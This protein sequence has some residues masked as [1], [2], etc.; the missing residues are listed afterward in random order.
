MERSAGVLLAISSLPSRYGIGDFGSYAKEFIQKLHNTGFKIWQI[1]PLNPLGFGN[2]P[3]QPYSSKAMDEIYISLELLKKDGLL[4]TL[5]KE[6]NSLSN[7]V[8]YEKARLYKSKYLAKAYNNFI[9]KND[10][11][12][13]N[14]WLSE[15]K[16]VENYSVFLTFKK[17]NELR[18]WTEW[19]KEQKEWIRD[20]KFDIEPWKDEILYVKWLQFILFKQWNELHLFANSLGIKIMG[21]IPFYVG[22]DSADVWENQHYFLLDNDGNPSFIAGVP[23]DYFSVTGQRWGN[24]IYNWEVMEEKDFDFWV[25]RIGFNAKVFDIIRIDHFRA[26]DTYWKIPS[27][28]ETAIEGTWENAPGYAL[29]DKLYA[30]FPNMNI[31][32]EDLGD[33]FDSV[34]VLRD[35]YNLPG[36]NILQFTFDINKEGYGEKDS[37]NQLV[38][39]GTHDNETIMGWINAM[40]NEE[41]TKLVNKLH[42]VGIFDED[43]AMG[44]VRLAMNNKA[45]YAILPMQD[46]LSLDNSARMNTPST[47]GSPDWEWKMI[48]FAG[49]EER[50]PFFNELIQYSNR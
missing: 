14:E 46:L 38:Y 44:F 32:A 3:Y 6:F 21:D 47:I 30:T 23:P 16:W 28:C 2:S 34:L 36:M 35:H 37:I 50:C 11:V 5:P 31:V 42:R 12:E 1:L 40:N 9:K 33:L 27:S 29:F 15:N 45:N 43:Y 7:V 13:F 49:F 41:K 26:F 18:M 10:F 39:T 22:I 24:P 4:S 17:H 8:D 48:D 20:H 25:D 19:P